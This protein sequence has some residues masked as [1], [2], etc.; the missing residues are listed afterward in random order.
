ME[1]GIYSFGDT[2]RDKNGELRST[3][4]AIANLFEAI[5]LADAS[6]L[7][8]FGVGEHHTSEMPASSP[9]TVLAA[10][11]AATSRIKLGSS[12]SVLSTD[13]P[14]RVFQQF[15]IVDAISGGRAEIIAGRGSST[16]SFPLFGYSLDDYNELYA[17]KL[18]LL[19]KINANERVTWQGKYRPALHDVLVLPRPVNGTLPISLGTGGT[20]ESSVRAGVMGL[21]VVYA[22]IGGYP[23]HF[24]P[25]ANLYRQAAKS[26]G[27]P[28]KQITVAVANM[29]FVANKTQDAKEL[30]WHH[31]ADAMT[32]VGKQRGWA[33]PNRGDFERQAGPE[34][35]FFV[36]DP[37]EVAR[38]IVALQRHLGHVRQFFQMD[39]GSM[40][41]SEYLKS[42]ELLG[43]EVLPRVR[44][45]LAE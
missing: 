33:A 25:L 37:D 24:A 15:A 31:W 41:H 17:E 18:E 7:D 44:K 10:A 11:A 36:G 14:V 26:A 40:P 12:V 43:T 39:L 9:A 1:L 23:K 38:R 28:E 21:P 20:P 2:Q 19:L 6:G 42:I 16:E 22:I 29:G 5:K 4:E 30:F 13:D 27:H 8:Y 3:S 45:L 32:L 35:A 34:G